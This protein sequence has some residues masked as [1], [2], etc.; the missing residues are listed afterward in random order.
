MWVSPIQCGWQLFN[1]LHVTFISRGF[2]HRLSLSFQKEPS[3]W[4]WPPLNHTC[5]LAMDNVPD[6]MGP[7]PDPSYQVALPGTGCTSRFLSFSVLT[8]TAPL[9]SGGKKGAITEASNLVIGMLA[10]K[11]TCSITS[12]SI[13]AQKSSTFTSLEAKK[14]GQ[15]N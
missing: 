4:A 7:F 15:V 14:S 5:C 6:A 8:T 10:G 12:V 13:V 9:M 2:C 1:T 11:A 3:R